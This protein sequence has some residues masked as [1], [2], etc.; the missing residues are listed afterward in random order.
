MT[1]ILAIES[2]RLEEIVKISDEVLKMYGSNI[3]IEKNEE[4]LLLD[5]VYGLMLRSGN[6]AAESI[7]CFVS[8][9]EL[10]FVKLMNNKAKE[11]NLNNTTYENPHGLDEETTNYSSS[12]DLVK[13][14]SYAYQ[15][16]VF[17]NVVKTKYYSTSS[18][19]KSYTWKNRNELLFNYEKATGGKTGY[20]PKAGRI[21]V[22]SATNDDLNIAIATISNA[23][24][25]YDYHQ[26]LYEEMFKK[27][28]N[29]VILNK[30][31]INIS[32]VS[33]KTYLKKEFK[34][35]MTAKEKEKI[36]IKTE[37]KV[38]NKRSIYGNIYVYLDDDI[39]Y[40]DYIYVKNDKISTMKKIKLFFEQLLD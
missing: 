1:A 3:Y 7:S 15:S 11:L 21:F 5:L 37:K 40:K 10:S 14:Y 33:E 39:I 19:L 32:D 35:P 36:V 22:S 6:D 8:K 29:Y 13:L 2:N 23:S 24:Y 12:N 26:S 27:Y 34:Y 38:D 9:D 20:T 18:N 16:P 31:D 4:M 28:K 30:G 17:R 25:L